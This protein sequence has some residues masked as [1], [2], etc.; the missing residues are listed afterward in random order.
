MKYGKVDDPQRIKFQLP[1]D[2]PKLFIPKT[3]EEGL[4]IYSGGTMWNIPKWKGKIY[5]ENT[6]VKDFIQAYGKQFDSIE[7]NA[8]HYRTPTE[9]TV[10]KWANSM[11]L[12]FRFCPKWPQS[13]THYRRFKHCEI[14]TEEF[15]LAIS[16][17]GEK[18]G[19]CFIQLAPNF[20]PKHSE[21]LIEYLQKL[22]DD[23]PV[24]VEFRHPEWFQWGAKAEAVW[25]LLKEKG[26]GAVISATAGRRDALHMRMTNPILILRYGGYDLDPSDETRI[27][28]W[29]QRIAEWR[30]KGLK[31]VY[32]LIHQ[33]D[34]LMTPETVQL[35]QKQI[36][37]KTGIKI[38]A[39]EIQQ[40]LF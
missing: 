11:P 18:L 5:P 6:R 12:H 36:L 16:A 2:H 33:S 19:Q 30:E 1:P 15:L 34:S 35:F 17:L 9:G 27:A 29:S 39:P 32:L 28:Q 38:Q 25:E 7:L 24:N 22:P 20:S 3:R 23:L 26:Y 21:A 37:A 10:R 14:Q 31:E 40:S 4:K 13:I 8:T